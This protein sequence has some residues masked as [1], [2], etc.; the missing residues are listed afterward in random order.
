[1]K[2]RM[3]FMLGMDVQ[4]NI[5]SYAVVSTKYEA[6]SSLIESFLPLVEY[7]L[8]CFDG[9]CVEEVGINDVYEKVYGYR[10]H[11]A[12]LSQLLRVLRNQG[13]IVK[14]KNERIQVKKNLLKTYDL[15][16]E[17]EYKLRA[18]VN[19]IN[20]STFVICR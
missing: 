20:Q 2:G 12:I 13:K 1:M 10:I 6:S 16:Q 15:N 8:S 19:F 14:I 18:F 4:F 3:K 7:A 17:Y 9:D 5:I 11:S